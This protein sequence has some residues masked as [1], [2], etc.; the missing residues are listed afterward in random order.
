MIA[1]SKRQVQID[2][3]LRAGATNPEIERALGLTNSTVKQHIRLL[4]EKLGVK[5]RMEFHT[6]SLKREN[7]LLRE[8]IQ[9]MIDND[10]NEVVADSG[11]TVIDQWRQDAIRLLA[12]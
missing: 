7:Q 2:N 9:S 11:E 10:P 4:Y 8:L 5:S 12:R 1:L 3:M 6:A